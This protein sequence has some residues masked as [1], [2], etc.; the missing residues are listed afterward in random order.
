[1]TADAQ[2][3]MDVR[4][5]LRWEPLL[6]AAH[7]DVEVHLGFAVL[8][9][10][11]NSHL[12][13]RAAQCATEQVPGVRLVLN[14]IDVAVPES[15]PRGDADI[16]RSAQEMLQ[17]TSSVA[18]G[19]KAVVDGGWITLSGSVHWDYQK[20]AAAAA[21]RYVI[22]AAGV[23]DLVT[24]GAGGSPPASRSEIDRVLNWRA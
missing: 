16:A 23:T 1:M 18:E 15:N 11:V 13:R 22:G 21:V 6:G 3:R 8:A 10:T 7:I 17:W 20:R 5:Q 14:E 9:G 12:E 24:Q 19:V 4:E 2:L